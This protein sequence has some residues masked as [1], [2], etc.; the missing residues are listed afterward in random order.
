M[1]F[2][3]GWIKRFWMIVAMEPERADVQP[4]H[5]TPVK[6]CVNGKR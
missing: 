4:A 3:N 5:A 6:M 2:R 1:L